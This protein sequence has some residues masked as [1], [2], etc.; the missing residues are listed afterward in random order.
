VKIVVYPHD[1]G[2]GGSQLNAIEL[3]ARTRDLGH[4]VIVYGRPGAL[5]AKV[6]ELALPFVEAP[7][8][9][10]RPSP[11]VVRDLA[12]LVREQGVDVL[13]GYEWPPGLECHLAA[14]RADIT[15]VTTVMS[16]AVAPFL[17]RTAPLV[18]GTEQIADTERRT[19]R[20]SVWVLEPPVDLESNR[21]GIAGPVPGVPPDG[22]PTIVVVSR[23]APELKLEGILTAIDAV[24]AVNRV[25]PARLV[26]VGDGS[27]RD[28][29]AGRATAVNRRHGAGTV[30]LT[31]ELFD[32]RPAY[33]VADVAI[34]M[35]GSA[36]RA[37]AF[38]KPLVVQGEQGFFRLL[39]PESAPEFLWQGWYGRGGPAD[40]VTELAR[41]LVRLLAESGERD[42]LGAFGRALVED[43]FSLALAA[44]RQ[45]EVYE[46]AVAAPRRGALLD[47][48]A[49]AGR[50]AQVRLG[51]R[52][53]RL[54]GGVAMD[55]FNARP[56]AGSTS[57]Q[58][59]VA[60]PIAASSSSARVDQL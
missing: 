15:A 26:V 43:R 53:R 12:R 4:D 25:R 6:H 39:T 55:D 21:P 30:V 18:V 22:R 17:P 60:S 8:P 59:R 14:R 35:G 10:V 51:R 32:P 50:F 29:V 13:H 20:R 2:M 42:R 41:L 1:L 31:G 57:A 37:M 49:S 33:D 9:A 47:E 11:A 28:Q 7:E 46:A 58:L 34:G 19:G 24:D 36:L 45:V 48:I 3:A 38:A 27:A 23:L 40:P 56:L 16:M 54:R 52:L 44:S 5:V